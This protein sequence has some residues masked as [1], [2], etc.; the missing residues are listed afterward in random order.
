MITTNSTDLLQ[1]L[2]RTFG[3]AALGKLLL[4]PYEPNTDDCTRIAA[5]LSQL[6][7]ENSWSAVWSVALAAIS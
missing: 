3:I 2:N 4:C 7:T 6:A 1:Q 5:R